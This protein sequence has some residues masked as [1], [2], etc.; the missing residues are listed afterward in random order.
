[1]LAS[2]LVPSLK[3][4]IKILFRLTF[5]TYAPGIPVMLDVIF[6]DE[7]KRELKFTGEIKR[8]ENLEQML[9]LIEQT[10]EV[11]FEKIANEIRIK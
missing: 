4:V 3:L 5:S 7:T 1:M 2:S 8:Y 10:Q 6:E 11:K 9:Q